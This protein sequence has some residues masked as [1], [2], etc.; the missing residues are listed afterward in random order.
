MRLYDLNSDL[1][2]ELSSLSLDATS[3]EPEI[4]QANSISFALSNSSNGDA[5]NLTVSFTSETPISPSNG[6]FVKYSFPPEFDLSIFDTENV[7]ATG[8]FVDAEGKAQSSIFKHNFEDEAE[9]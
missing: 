9:E 1:T 6:C 7:E 3:L 5:T 8:M 4:L 2:N